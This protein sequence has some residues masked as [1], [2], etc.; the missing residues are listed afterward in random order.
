MMRWILEDGPLLGS[1]RGLLPAL[2]GRLRDAGMPV[3]RIWYG[4]VVL[5]P[6]LFATGHEWRAGADVVT[7]SLRHVDRR[8]LPVERSPT[9][10]LSPARPLWRQR[11][12]G[13]EPPEVGILGELRARGATDFAIVALGRGDTM[14]AALSFATD[15]DG[16][17]PDGF[18]ALLA[19]LRPALSAVTRAYE[20][21]ELSRT[22]LAT[23]L[24]PDAGR[25]VL[26]GQIHRG[27]GETIPAAVWFSDLRDFT[28]LSDRLPR[29][30][31]LGLLNDA[32]EIQVDAV[33]AHGG[34][35]L[36]FMGD[37][38]LAIFAADGESGPRGACEAA[39]A[40]ARACTRA[41]VE[42]NERRAA[43]GAVRIRLG[44]ALH[45][46]DVMYGNIGSAGRLDFTVIGPAVNRAARL[47]SLCVKLGRSVVASAEFAHHCGESMQPLGEHAVKGVE[48]GLEV[49][50]PSL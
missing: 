18:E 10:M 46:G 13:S 38:M 49:F 48:R 4:T 7:S 26:A 11:L 17:F 22:L 16:G 2:A 20:Q 40:A 15:A 35:V 39:L 21:E 28:G 34:A 50:A 5:H 37:G 3:S 1:P 23:Y 24:G 44:L 29:E 42:L 25:R 36:K 47:E 14:H 8:A 12:D 32:F 9:A 45:V 30:Q 19:E 27:D 43:A 41:L 31:L 6:Q 33:E